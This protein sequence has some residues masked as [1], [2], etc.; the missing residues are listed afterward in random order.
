[1]KPRKGERDIYIYVEGP[2]ERGLRAIHP[3]STLLT[4]L[5]GSFLQLGSGDDVSGVPSRLNVVVANGSTATFC[6]SRF[7]L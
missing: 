1:M 5:W 4:I 2:F 3:S 7:L 6:P